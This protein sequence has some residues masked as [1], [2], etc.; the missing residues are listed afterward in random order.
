MVIN[1]KYSEIL[2]SK[3]IAIYYK[4]CTR[5]GVKGNDAM[6]LA[7]S[8][9][10]LS[11]GKIKSALKL[12]VLSEEFLYFISIGVIS[13]EAGYEIRKLSD[14]KKALILSDMR[15]GVRITKKYVLKVKYS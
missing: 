8:R 5:Q 1:E 9:F 10:G 7:Q 12:A 14:E 6:L 4:V 3:E 2:D 13:K 15:A 11:K